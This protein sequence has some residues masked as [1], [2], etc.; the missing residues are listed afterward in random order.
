VMSPG[1]RVVAPVLGAFCPFQHRDGTSCNNNN[2][3]KR[4]EKKKTF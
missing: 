4:K 2:K 1:R 3:E